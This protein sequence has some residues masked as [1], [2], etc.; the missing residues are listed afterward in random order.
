MEISENYFKNQSR[1]M[2]MCE[3]MTT[4][5]SSIRLFRI[6]LFQIF[7]QKSWAFTSLTC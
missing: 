5:N 3:Q 2:I 4:Y 7:I 1:T 6:K